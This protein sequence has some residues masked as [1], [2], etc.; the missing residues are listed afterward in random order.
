MKNFSLKEM[1]RCAT[2]EHWEH[3]TYSCLAEDILNSLADDACHCG[4]FSWSD[5]FLSSILEIPVE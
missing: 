4:K 1:K 3:Y 5:D 2:C